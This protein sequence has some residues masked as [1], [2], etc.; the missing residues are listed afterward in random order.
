MSD[1]NKMHLTDTIRQPWYS[2]EMTVIFT[3]TEAVYSPNWEWLA[4][5]LMTAGH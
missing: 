1:D 5:L 4:K 3:V 2:E